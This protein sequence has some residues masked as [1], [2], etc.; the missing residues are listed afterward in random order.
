M[1]RSRGPVV[2]AAAP[3]LRPTFA[4][5]VCR[6]PAPD[7]GCCRVANSV[8]GCHLPAPCAIT[9]ISFFVCTAAINNKQRTN[10]SKERKR[11]CPFKQLWGQSNCGYR[12]AL[13]VP[14]VTERIVPLLAFGRLYVG[15]Y[16]RARS[17]NGLIN[18]A[19]AVARLWAAWGW[20]SPRNRR[21][22][23]Q[24]RAQHSEGH[25]HFRPG[26]EALGQL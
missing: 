21:S 12:G 14:R 2:S 8:G 22:P 5:S 20:P 11:R 15:L 9:E 10:Q 6:R 7:V 23:G 26:L 13:G 4:T 25:H 17:S 19:C 24:H 3:Y 1:V 18:S 16:V